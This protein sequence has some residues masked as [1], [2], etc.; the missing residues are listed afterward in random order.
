[1]AYAESHSMAHCNFMVK[2]LTIFSRYPTTVDWTEYKKLSTLKSVL[3]HL[4]S[5][6]GVEKSQT[7]DIA[8]S[9]LECAVTWPCQGFPHPGY[10]STA[11]YVIC[12]P[13]N[14]GVISAR[15]ASWDC[16]SSKTPPIL[17]TEVYLSWKLIRLF[18]PHP[19]TTS[20]RSVHAPFVQKLNDLTLSLVKPRQY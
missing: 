3:C 4:T 17:R 2:N 13:E 15:D 9:T 5:Q 8:V 19:R 18:L 1:M 11:V 14:C 7:W 16:H 6:W 12:D 20:D 10:Q